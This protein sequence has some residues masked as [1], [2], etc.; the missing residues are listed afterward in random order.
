[1]TGNGISI[2]WDTNFFNEMRKIAY[3]LS[4]IL[5]FLMKWENSLSIKWDT[6]FFNEMKKIA[7]R[8]NPELVRE[9]IPNYPGTNSDDEVYRSQ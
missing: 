7:Y 3:R 1:M 2:K 6:N 9:L 5:I 4:E 8:T